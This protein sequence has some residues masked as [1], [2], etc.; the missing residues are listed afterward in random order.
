MR[1]PQSE[2][3]WQV[4]HGR[5]ARQAARV[6]PGNQWPAPEKTSRPAGSTPPFFD[7]NQSQFQQ[8]RSEFARH[9]M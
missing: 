3:V 5:T 2:L 1:N 4:V 6:L 7:L 9:S 8:K